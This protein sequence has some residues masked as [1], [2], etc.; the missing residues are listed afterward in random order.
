M[1]NLTSLLGSSLGKAI[2]SRE[3]EKSCG[4][5]LSLSTLDCCSADV[6]HAAVGGVHR[7]RNVS[8]PERINSNRRRGILRT[9]S[10]RT[11]LSSATM[12][13]TLATESCGSPDSA[14]G[15]STFPGAS[16]HFRLLVRGTQIAVLMRL[17]LIALHWTTTTG[18]R[19]PGSDPAD[20][21]RSAHQTSACS[22]TT[23]LAAGPAARRV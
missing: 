7:P 5:L 21:S 17:R 23:P 13:E 8:M 14:L 11:C 19:Y 12:R 22:I 10:V 3:T 20:S 2:D 18:R 15:T 6:G 9:R 4:C 1:A 16:A